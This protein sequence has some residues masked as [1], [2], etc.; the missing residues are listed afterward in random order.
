MKNITLI[1]ISDYLDNIKKYAYKDVSHIQNHVLNKNPYTSNFIQNCLQQQTPQKLRKLYIL[2]Q[3]CLF[4][5]KTLSIFGLYVL[6]FIIFKV[7]GVKS[8]VDFDK[9]VFLI[10]T[11]FLVNQVI[12]NNNFEDKYFANLYEILNK[13]GKNFTFLPRLYGVEKNP[14]KLFKLMKIL[15]KD[16]RYN[17]LFEYELL[18]F[19]DI[20]KIFFF[21]ITYPI[22]QFKIFQNSESN[23]DKTFNYELF[24]CLPKTSFEA[25]VRYLVGKKLVIRFSSNLHIISWQEFQNLEKSFNRSIR[26]SNKKNIF[27]YGC[28]FLV[29]Y[30]NYLSMHIT[31]VDVDLNITPHQT[32]LNG[33]YNYSHSSKHNFKEGVSLRYKNIFRDFNYNYDVGNFLVLL[34]MDVKDSNILLSKVN[35]IDNLLIKIHPATNINQFID[36]KKSTWKYT[37]K[38]LYNLFDKTSI[39]FVPTMTGTALEAVASGVSVIVISD[40]DK[41]LVNPLINFGQS[42][43]WD[44]AT[45]T[46][47]LIE[48]VNILMMYR[49]DNKKEV[50]LISQW[51][52][53]NFF[54][55][56]NEK[57]II[58]AFDIC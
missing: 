43:I 48:K 49:K 7:K 58:K 2:R 37:D 18:N 47:E 56:P 33:K 53:D 54:I 4:Y 25:Y 50:M 19:Q 35:S 34:G 24:S 16:N 3:I 55:E 15:K 12:K 29:K 28:E 31:D 41:F 11:F 22:K 26:E 32:L 14:L 42:K 27:I 10:D 36:N 51:Y 44:I 57:N 5:L 8:K 30:E 52:R 21:I 39:V 40:S 45:N 13:F 6:S 17:Y 38:N 9:D 23:F 46:N 1:E 20:V